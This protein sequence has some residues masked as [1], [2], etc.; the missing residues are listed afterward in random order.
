MSDFTQRYLQSPDWHRPLEDALQ[1]KWGWGWRLTQTGLQLQMAL[2]RR[3]KRELQLEVRSFVGHI[4]TLHNR[5]YRKAY[6]SRL[7]PETGRPVSGRLDGCIEGIRQLKTHYPW[8][9]TTIEQMIFLE[10]FEKGEQFAA[11]NLGIPEHIPS[12][13][14]YQREDEFQVAD[15]GRET[16]AS[17]EARSS[18]GESCG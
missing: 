6:P 4:R 12:A 17:G 14:S 3:A 16:E 9:S 7:A 11:C 2:F 8:A 5:G 15:D 18:R 10:G 13:L 1:S